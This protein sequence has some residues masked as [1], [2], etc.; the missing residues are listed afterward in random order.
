[1]LF[2]P[3]C[4]RDL[5]EKILRV[6]WTVEQLQNILLIANHFGDYVDK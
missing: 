4:D 5:Y 1:M 6:N 2:M 3:H